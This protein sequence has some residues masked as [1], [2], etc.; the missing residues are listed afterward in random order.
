LKRVSKKTV[1]KYSGAEE[2]V[3][4]IL[5]RNDLDSL[6]P[7]KACAQASHAANQMAQTLTGFGTSV[8]P[9]PYW[10]QTFNRWSS[11]A[12]GFGTCLVYADS[13]GNIESCIDNWMLINII[14]GKLLDP[15]YPLKDGDV[16][17]TFPLYTCAW[18]FG[19]RIDLQEVRNSFRLMP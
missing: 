16:T 5:M 1:K 17:H 8:K 18:L 15:S 12:D 6:N 2:P 11:G 10:Q 14:T 4:I 13:W 9:T 19:D 3:L 7:G